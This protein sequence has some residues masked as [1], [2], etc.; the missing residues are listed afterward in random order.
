[1]KQE[2]FIGEIAELLGVSKDTLRI[3]EEQGLICPKRDE[4]GFRRYGEE[5]LYRLI[6]VKVYRENA[7]PMK[8]IRRLMEKTS[9][10]D[11]IE[12]LEAQIQAERMEIL[13]HQRNMERLE[14]AKTYYLDEAESFGYYQAENCYRVSPLR[15]N[16]FDVLLDWFRCSRKDPDMTVCYLNAEYSLEGGFNRPE[17][18]YV[19][20]KES[21]ARYLQREELLKGENRIPGGSCLKAVLYT[22]KPLPDKK[23]L[24]TVWERAKKTGVNLVGRAYTHFQYVVYES[25]E[26]PCYMTEVLLPLAVCDE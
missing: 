1:M 24:E 21:D 15:D 14:L 17:T 12:L 9:R 16:Y 10:R 11:T 6:T 25:E 22:E 4:N 13:R 3:Y 7:F 19:M 18:A 26:K 2:L 20:I 5:E 23:S 8:E